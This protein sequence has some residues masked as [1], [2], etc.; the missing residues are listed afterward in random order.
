MENKTARKLKTLDDL[1]V[2]G[3]AVLVRV[4][5]NV[6]TND[7]GRVEETEDYRIKAALATIEELM[8]RRCKVL[9]LTH[10]GRPGESKE[11][12]ELGP[13][14]DR[15]EGL[16]GEE[17]TSINKLYGDGVKAVL[18]GMNPGDV[19]LL[20]NVRM[21]VREEEGSEQFAREIC[22]N[23]EVYINEAFSVSHR[24]HASVSIAP[25]LLSSGA[26]RRT[27]E[28]VAKLTKLRSNPAKPYVAI[29]SGAKIE[30]K[31]GMLYRLLEQV[32]KLCI[33]GRLA[34]VFLAAQ[35]KR[36]DHF[37]ADET[38]VARV[39]LDKGGDKI[40]LPVDVVIGNED[41]SDAV[42][43]GV[44]EI[45]EG[46]AGVFDVGPKTVELFMK[47]AREAATIMWN[48]PMGRFEVPA[49]AKATEALATELAQLSSYRVVGGG[50]TIIALQ[51]AK[52]LN[53]YDHVSVGGGAMIAFLENKR[54]PGL[55]PLYVSD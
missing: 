9:L 18:G 40:V 32:D 28:E 51:K 27:V 19:A 10:R 21:D 23:A 31:I 54:M 30:T 17:V 14:R 49:Y 55:E 33:G 25:R 52:V 7:S 12:T 39:L 16:L 42:V 8:Q 48:G 37:T 4:D 5:F 13:V 44:D 41:G 35:G 15:L 29:T 46:V 3:K 24:N 50:D 45:P 1:P 43:A 6:A 2:D 22:D 34:N 11:N 20:P 53:K 38:S 47:Y 36:A 26:G